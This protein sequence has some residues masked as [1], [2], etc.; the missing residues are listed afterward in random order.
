MSTTTTSTTTT[1]IKTAFPTTK[2]IGMPSGTVAATESEK[3]HC[4]PRWGQEGGTDQMTADEAQRRIQD[5]ETQV[6]FF[7][8]Q[9][10]GAGE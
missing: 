2:L 3:E 1:K 10:T 7:K 6:H 8:M 5:L 9:S 4:Y